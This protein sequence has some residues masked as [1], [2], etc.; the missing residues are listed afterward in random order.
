MDETPSSDDKATCDTLAGCNRLAIFAW[1]AIVAPIAVGL[2]LGVAVVTGG[3]V[4]F[5]WFN[6][7]PAANV[8]LAILFVPALIAILLAGILYV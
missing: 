3:E 8:D 1:G 5:G 7:P 2:A 6:F 4:L